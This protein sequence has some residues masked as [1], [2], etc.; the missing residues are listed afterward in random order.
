MHSKVMAWTDT[1]TH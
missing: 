1:C